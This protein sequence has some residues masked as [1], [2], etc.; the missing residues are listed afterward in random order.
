MGLIV[1]QSQPNTL[2]QR[3]R[4]SHIFTIA[5]AVLAIFL[6]LQLKNANQTATVVYSD[7]VVGITVDYPQNWLLDTTGDAVLKVSDESAEGFKTSIEVRVLPLG[8]G[9]AERNL[10]DN[11]ILSRS[12]SLAS[13]DVLERESMTLGEDERPA[14]SLVFT[15]VA[16]ESNPFLESLPTVVEG[17]DVI[18]T[19]GGQALI[20]TF[21]S[22]A[23]S[24]EQNLAIFQRFLDEIDF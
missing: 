3:Q 11:L 17:M 2:S 13:F 14:T 23:T 21:L 6:A 24:Y 19:Q 12:Q 22:D 15:Y 5:F 18:T 16:S 8:V 9:L 20:V 4:W 1:E 7:P 10:V